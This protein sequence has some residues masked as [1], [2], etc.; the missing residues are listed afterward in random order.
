MRI[1]TQAKII[2]PHVRGAAVNQ[3]EQWVGARRV[4]PGRQCV[5]A[6]D[7]LAALGGEPKLAQGL[8]VDLGG[9][10]GVDP[11]ERRPLPGGG[12]DPHHLR[13]VRRAL[14]DC[15]HAHRA[16]GGSRG[17]LK[18]TER[19]ARHRADFLLLATCDRRAEQPLASGVFSKEEDRAVVWADRI[20]ANGMVCAARDAAWSGVTAP[21]PCPGHEPAV[22]E[23]ML[24]RRGHHPVERLAVRTELRRVVIVLAPRQRLRFTARRP[25]KPQHL[26]DVAVRPVGAVRRRGEYHA[27]AVGRPRRCQILATGAQ[28]PAK[29]GALD[30][31]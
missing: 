17:H 28:L 25:H 20:R 16:S 18:A 27:A 29:S 2:S 30:E 10:R 21:R 31:P 26:H 5:E 1:P 15:R 9:A 14:P 4:E 23:R 3:H 13:R 11:G 12:I 8:P 19:A 24:V 6:V 22:V 7:P